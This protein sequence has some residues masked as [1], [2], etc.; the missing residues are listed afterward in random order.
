MMK[1][2]LPRV[3]LIPEL[4]KY[5][6]NSQQQKVKISGPSYIVYFYIKCSFLMCVL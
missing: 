4:K 6:I 3:L 1:I 2:P 5:K